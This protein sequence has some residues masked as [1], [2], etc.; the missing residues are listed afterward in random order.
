MNKQIKNGL[1]AVGAMLVTG[2]AFAADADPGLDAIGG[3]GAR[4][5]TYIAAAAAAAVVV[6]GGF[7]GIS[8]MKKTFSR[9][10]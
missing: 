1:V 6:A 5:A 2:I 4:A 9:A 3:L 10:G 8:M 7:W